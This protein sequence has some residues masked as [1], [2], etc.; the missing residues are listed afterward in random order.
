V[1]A[2]SGGA[3][4]LC[5]LL[6][7]WAHWP[8][9]RRRLVAAHF[10][11]RLRGRESLA[12]A[13]FCRRVSR[14]LGISHEEGAWRERPLKA[15][16]AQAREARQAFLGTVLRKRRACVLWTGH[17]LDDIA[18]T[19]LMRL[20][21]GSGSAG[22]SAPRPVQ[23][24]PD[25]VTLLRPLSGL[26][27][28]GVSKFL[29]QAGAAWREDSSNATGQYFRNR[30]RSEVLPAWC[31]SAEGRDALAGAALS[32]EWLEEDEEALQAWLASLAVLQPGPVLELGPLLDK[33]R[34]LVRRALHLWLGATVYRGDL[35]RQGFEQ[36]LDAC[37]SGRSTRFSLGREGFALIRRKVLSFERSGA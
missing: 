30:V 34:A 14:G 19:M 8:E 29:L 20:A 16:E 26:S 37:A 5:L 24:R 9:R 33:P 28:A 31:A 12:D 1:A 27:K 21:R 4:S 10:N 7:L 17:Q 22:L 32:R 3:D 35:A 13:F 36:L 23:Q 18:E 2:F 25:G 6:L 11:H 15:S